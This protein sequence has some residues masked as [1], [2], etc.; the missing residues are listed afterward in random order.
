MDPEPEPRDDAADKRAALR[1]AVGA[2][3]D[4]IGAINARD[5]GRLC[6]LLPPG[7]ERALKPAGGGA[8]CAARIGSSIG[9]EDPR[10]FPVWKRTTLSAFDSTAIGRDLDSAR[11]TASIVTSFADRT[12]PSVESDIAYL[13]RVTGEWRLAKPT[14]ALY[15]AI[16]QPEIPISTITPP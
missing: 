8:S 6:D 12:E 1:A 15:R 10:G 14:G 7:A 2:Y 16:G 4:Y 3:E 5:G 9:Y 11:L 13:E